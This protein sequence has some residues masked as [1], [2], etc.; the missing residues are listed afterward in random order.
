MTLICLRLLPRLRL[1]LLLRLLL[2][3]FL[4]LINTSRRLGLGLWVALVIT[5]DGHRPLRWLLW[6]GIGNCGIIVRVHSWKYNFFTG[7]RS[8]RLL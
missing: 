2:I 1:R 8:R 7:L 6:R 4:D 5:Q 3:H